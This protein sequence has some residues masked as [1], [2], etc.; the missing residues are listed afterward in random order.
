MLKNA[1]FILWVIVVIGVVLSSYATVV[2]P[3]VVAITKE[4]NQT[5]PTQIP[6]FD[7]SRFHELDD[8]KYYG[9]DTGFD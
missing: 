5:Y 1:N 9:L 2:S 4:V 3:P 8:I 7:K 6:D